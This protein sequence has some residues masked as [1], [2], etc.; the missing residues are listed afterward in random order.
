MNSQLNPGRDEVTA[1]SWS[2]RS[3]ENIRKIQAVAFDL[4][5]LMF[6]TEDLYDETLQV[7][8]SRRGRTFSRELKLQMMGLPGVE[9]AQVLIQA[10]ELRDQPQDLLAEAHQHLAGLLPG[11]LQPMPGLLELLEIIDEAGLPKSIATSSSPVFAQTALTISG[12]KD[13]FEFVLT[14]ED[15][16]RGKPN[17]DIY[18][19]SAKRHGVVPSSMLVLEDSLIGSR[20]AAAA[21]TIAVAVPG[22][23]SEHQVFDHV[24]YRFDSLAAPMLQSMLRQGCTN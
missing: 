11:R 23:H 22:H 21:G 2:E 20:A 6:N 15:V 1:N 10:C 17:P 9:A 13:R 12:L 5:G 3:P 18:L 7:L 24:A 8:M 19:E 4:D 16:A 14:T